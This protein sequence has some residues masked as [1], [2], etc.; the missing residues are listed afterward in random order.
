MGRS[1]RVPSKLDLN[2]GICIVDFNGYSMP[3]HLPTS[4][5]ADY[6]PEYGI[7]RF[8]GDWRHVPDMRSNK[9]PSERKV[10]AWV[11]RHSKL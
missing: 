5:W 9:E 1:K 4:F 6:F 8:G 2:E 11:R 3:S 7:T 10:E